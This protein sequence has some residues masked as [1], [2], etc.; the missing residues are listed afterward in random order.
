MSWIRFVSLLAL[1]LFEYWR[2]QV[3]IAGSTHMQTG[4][5][6]APHAPSNASPASVPFSAPFSCAYIMKDMLACSASS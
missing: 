2:F 5:W 3:F 1:L 4:L 6:V